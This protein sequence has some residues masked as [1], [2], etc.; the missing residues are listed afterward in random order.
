LELFGDIEKLSVAKRKFSDHPKVLFRNAVD[1]RSRGEYN[2][3]VM[4]DQLG[5]EQVLLHG[6]ERLVDSEVE[7]GANN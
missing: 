2:I 3:F 7:L 5:I 1:G 6:A 4:K